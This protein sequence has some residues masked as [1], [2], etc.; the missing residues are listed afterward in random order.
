MVE[1]VKA[2]GEMAC[3][4]RARRDAKAVS[5]DL[6]TQPGL[7][8]AITMLSS[9][10]SERVRINRKA[11]QQTDHDRNHR[12]TRRREEHLHRQNWQDACENAIEE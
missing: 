3:Q 8:R 2:T 10:Q 11:S 9:E 12:R 1:V 5:L 4:Y 7:A 6:T